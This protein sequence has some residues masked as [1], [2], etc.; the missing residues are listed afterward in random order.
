VLSRLSHSQLQE[1]KLPRESSPRPRQR[2]PYLNSIQ[3]HVGQGILKRVEELRAKRGSN[4]G[5]GGAGGT[6]QPDKSS[7]PVTNGKDGSGV[8]SGDSTGGSDN[9]GTN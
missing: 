7:S 6:S 5:P 3:K 4:K 9:G 8:D 1:R 2:S